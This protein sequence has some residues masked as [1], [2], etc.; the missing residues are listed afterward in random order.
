MELCHVCRDGET[1]D[2]TTQ[3]PG[4]RLLAREMCV[5]ETG[6][7]SAAS[8]RSVARGGRTKAEATRTMLYLA[9]SRSA[10]DPAR[11]A[12]DDAATV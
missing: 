6:A 8:S 2:S 11:M 5:S 4:M 9:L 1:D 10:A 3:I 12:N 7:G